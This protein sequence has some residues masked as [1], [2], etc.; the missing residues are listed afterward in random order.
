MRRRLSQEIFKEAESK[1]PVYLRGVYLMA[2]F[3]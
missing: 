1:G 2:L 3:I